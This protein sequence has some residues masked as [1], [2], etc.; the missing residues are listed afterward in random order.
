MNAARP[1]PRTRP[2]ALAVIAAALAAGCTEKLVQPPPPDPVLGVP[3]S[4]QA[5]FAANCAFDGCHGGATPQQGLDLA[6]ARASWLSIV[7]VPSNQRSQFLRIAPGDSA[8]SYVVMKLRNDARKGGQPMPLGDYPM[9]ASLTMTIA[10]WAAQGAP[11][12]ELPAA[13]AAAAR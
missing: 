12:Q 8:N 13:V 2:F 10:A 3:D 6:S 1:A 11:G 9:E 7:G 4:V 5:V